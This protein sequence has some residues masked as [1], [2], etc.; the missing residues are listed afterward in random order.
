MFKFVKTII[1]YFVL[2]V[3]IFSE[4]KSI[5]QE[6]EFNF[7]SGMFDFSDY[8]ARSTLFGIQHQNE[9]LVIFFSKF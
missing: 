7:Y 4:E 8:C 1:I 2:T 5:D 6:H 9:N 3:A